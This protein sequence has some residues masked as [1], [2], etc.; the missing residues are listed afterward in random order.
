MCNRKSFFEKNGVDSFKKLFTDKQVEAIN[1]LVDVK[2]I[3][4]K[5]PDGLKK[6]L[7]SAIKGM[8]FVFASIAG[9]KLGDAIATEVLGKEKQ[10]KN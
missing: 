9:Y 2:S 7:P 3:I 6:A 4:N 8:L 5:L 10:K 1:Q